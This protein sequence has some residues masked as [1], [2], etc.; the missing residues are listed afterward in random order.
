M[1][2]VCV[3]DR[4]SRKI[5]HQIPLTSTTGAAGFTHDDERLAVASMA[6]VIVFDADRGRVVLELNNPHMYINRL[7]FSCRGDLHAAGGTIHHSLIVWPVQ[8]RGW[9][10]MQPVP[11]E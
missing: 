11:A 10:P 4:Q 2:H 3:L 6:Q 9:R 8:N 1:N 7:T 5:L